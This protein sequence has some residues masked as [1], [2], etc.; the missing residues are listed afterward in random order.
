MFNKKDFES[1]QY[2]IYISLK[3]SLK[4]KIK[5]HQFSN[6]YLLY[7]KFLELKQ[8][9]WNINLYVL[10][11]CNVII[12]VKHFFKFLSKENRLCYILLY[13]IEI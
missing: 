7:K 1:S 9:S 2:F 12:N 4:I 3:N 5:I 8:E 11:K 10:Y 13:N 6:Y